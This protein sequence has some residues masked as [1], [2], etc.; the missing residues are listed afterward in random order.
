MWSD[1]AVDTE[2]KQAYISPNLTSR[3]T[4]K[5]YISKMYT[6]QGKQE[7]YKTNKLF[8]FFALNRLNV[9]IFSEHTHLSKMALGKFM[10]IS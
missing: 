8:S 9:F 7:R 4:K 3:K 2:N 5:P 6:K 10:L 1:I